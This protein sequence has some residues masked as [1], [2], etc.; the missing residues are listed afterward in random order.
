MSAPEPAR[1]SADGLFAGAALLM[2]L[3]CVA[4]PA[5]IGAGAGSVIGGWLGI[6][7]AV[8]ISAFVG[9]LIHRRRGSRGC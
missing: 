2:V 6:V 1:R 9:V 5:A 4:L 3:R 7:C 8:L